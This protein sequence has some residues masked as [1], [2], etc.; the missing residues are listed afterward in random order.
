MK[1]VKVN[2]DAAY[3]PKARFDGNP[4]FY[5]YRTC[6]SDDSWTALNNEDACVNQDKSACSGDCK[7]SKK[8]GRCDDEVTSSY[9]ERRQ[10]RF[11]EHKGGE[12]ESLWS[13]MFR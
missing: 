13:R 2:G 8:N 12:N 9:C 10:E 1:S 4:L 5:S 7:W 11:E 3:L 6:G